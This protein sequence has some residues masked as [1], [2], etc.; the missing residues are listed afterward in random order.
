MKK[1]NSKKSLANPVDYSELNYMHDLD[2]KGIDVEDEEEDIEN[3]K[4]YYKQGQTM[5]T[6]GAHEKHMKY[7]R[8][9]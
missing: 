8:A 6:G 9:V 7:L 5:K 1:V 3:E 2:Q 4:T